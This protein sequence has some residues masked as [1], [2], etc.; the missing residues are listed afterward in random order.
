MHDDSNIRT[1][2]GNDNLHLVKDGEVAKGETERRI[3]QRIEGEPHL[4]LV[5]DEVV[6]QPDDLEPRVR[7]LPIDGKVVILRNECALLKQEHK[8]L[9]EAI[10]ALQ[11][12]RLPDQILLA[13]LKRKKLYLRDQIAKIE[14]KIRP[15]I[16]A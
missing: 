9:D 7:E 8:D 2:R 14:D 10:S 12:T 5:P 11:H 1:L 16:I 3:G 6:A 13:R 15:D 4:E